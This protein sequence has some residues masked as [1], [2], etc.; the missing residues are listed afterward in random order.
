MPVKK[1]SKPRSKP[2]SRPGRKKAAPPPAPLEDETVEVS[3][4][5]LEAGFELVVD[6]IVEPDENSLA[7]QDEELVDDDPLSLPRTPELAT[8]LAEDPVRLYLIDIGRVKLL[9]S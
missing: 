8:E 5:E 4:D 9:D 3:V 6:D 2:A 7:A 1:K